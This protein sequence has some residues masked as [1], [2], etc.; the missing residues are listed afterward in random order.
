MKKIMKFKGNKKDKTYCKIYKMTR[1]NKK[2]K[3]K[4]GEGNVT[5]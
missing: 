5:N 4:V 3:K 2:I 1:V